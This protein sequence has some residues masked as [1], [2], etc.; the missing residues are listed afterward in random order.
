MEVTAEALEEEEEEVPLEE[1]EEPL[2]KLALPALPALLAT[3]HGT[4]TLTLV[5]ALELIVL[6]SMTV[7]EN[8]SL[9]TP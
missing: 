4:M 8:V 7:L 5:P 3:T 2:L 9:F 1:E 6:V